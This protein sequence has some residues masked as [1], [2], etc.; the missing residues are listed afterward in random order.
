MRKVFLI[1][2]AL[3]LVSSSAYAAYEAIAVK[4]GGSIKGKV[5]FKGT[6]PADAV[7]KIVINKNPEVCGQDIYSKDGYREVRWI[8]VKGNTL[9]GVFVFIDGITKGKEWSAPEG[10]KYMI[11]QKNCR[12][13]KWAQ[14]I[15]RGPITIRHSDPPTVLH[16]INTREKIGVE[17]GSEVMKVIFNFAQPDPGDIEKE[18]K[19][20]RSQFIAINCEAHNFMFGFMMA[21]EH[22]YTEVVD[23]DGA[24]TIKDVPAGTYTVK[25]WHPR[26]GLKE[27]KVNISAKGSAEAN[28]EF[29]P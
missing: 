8:D 15:R 6:L 13:Q 27:A 9:R 24:F 4:D 7:E 18:I 25:A 19:P 21:P 12:F 17:S 2:A 5:T 26:F 11:E 20:R 22:P 28:F 3:M 10:G 16:N 14:V 29:S 23:D 1:L